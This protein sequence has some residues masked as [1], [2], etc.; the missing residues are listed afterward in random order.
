MAFLSAFNRRINSAEYMRWIPAVR[1]GSNCLSVAMS[2]G[3]PVIATA[4]SGNLDFMD[5][6]NSCLVPYSLI[7]I[8]DGS[9]P[10]SSNSQWA[11]PNL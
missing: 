5:S 7:E 11:E 2:L 4:Y 6:S 3:K 10:Y 9:T 8:G 1:E